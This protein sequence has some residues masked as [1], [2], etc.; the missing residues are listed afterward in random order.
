MYQTVGMR[1]SAIVVQDFKAD[2]PRLFHDGFCLPDTAFLFY[3]YGFT[4]FQKFD[5]F[6]WILATEFDFGFFS[7]FKHVFVA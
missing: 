2:F 6:Q 3:L 7:F 5:I 4:V 1:T